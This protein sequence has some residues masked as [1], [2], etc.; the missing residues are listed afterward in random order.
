MRNVIG[1][2]S[3]DSRL[4]YSSL[5]DNMVIRLTGLRQKGQITRLP[6][7]GSTQRTEQQ[8]IKNY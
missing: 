2:E 4:T 1:G 3:R 8:H 6:I 5:H 7:M